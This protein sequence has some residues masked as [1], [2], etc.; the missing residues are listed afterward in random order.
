MERFL[1]RHSVACT[2]V[3]L[4]GLFVTGLAM[5]SYSGAINNATLAGNDVDI[6][7]MWAFAVSTLSFFTWF[8]LVLIFGVRD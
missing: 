8:V 3:S 7:I 5:G 1:F 2:R 6:W 4:V